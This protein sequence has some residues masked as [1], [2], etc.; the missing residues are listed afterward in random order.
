MKQID[1]EL[2]NNKSLI[3]KPFGGA[4]LIGNPKVKRPFS[5]KHLIHIIL[6]SSKA[7]GAHSFLHTR[8][9]K[10]INDLVK[11]TARKCHVEIKDY[12]NV[13]NHLHILIKA[14]HRI[15]VTR[16][17]RAVSG[18]IPRKLLKCEK[19][20]PL[21]EPFWDGRPFTKIVAAGFR[22]F[23]IIKRYFD[24]NRRQAQVRVQ[25]FDIFLESNTS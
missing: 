21:D 25:G 1:F 5:R 13:G 22:P 14:G 11:S 16:F 6:K 9:K 12:V 2:I 15:S 23:K 20:N 18:L 17:L 4:K 3:G 24:K 7:K 8:N 19:G 10:T